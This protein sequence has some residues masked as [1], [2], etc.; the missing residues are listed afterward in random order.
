[1]V[2]FIKMLEGNFSVVLKPSEKMTIVKNCRRLVFI[3]AGSEK[4]LMK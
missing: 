4:F 1:M 3:E 2:R